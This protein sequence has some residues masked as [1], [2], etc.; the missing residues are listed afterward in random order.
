V[1]DRALASIRPSDGDDLVVER[2]P[3]SA[4]ARRWCVV[5][6][7]DDYTAKWFVVMVL[8]QLFRMSETTATAFMMAVHQQGRGIAGTYTRDI[9][10]TKAVEV[11]DLAREYGMPLK[12]TA[13]P[14]ED[15]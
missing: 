10:E 15:S 14:D 12:V 2:A 6:Y 4:R 13:E 1:Q 3:T 5:F 7:N 9:A 8:E 11:T